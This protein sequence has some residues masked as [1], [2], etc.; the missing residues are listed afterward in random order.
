MKT[1]DICKSYFNG[2]RELSDSKH[3]GCGR[4]FISVLKV[5]S[6]FTGIVPLLFGIAYGISSSPCL[7][8]RVTKEISP[9]ETGKQGGAL[10]G[11]LK[12]T[13]QEIEEPHL[14]PDD[15]LPTL[16]LSDFSLNHL[17]NGQNLVEDR[18]RFGLLS[19]EQVKSI[20][21]ILPN[22]LLKFITV[23]QFKALDNL[24]CLEETRINILFAK[25]L[26]LLETLT[27]DQAQSVLPKLLVNNEIWNIH[28]FRC[29]DLFVH[30]DFSNLK[31][32]DVRNLLN[33]L[34][35]ESDFLPW[36]TCPQIE[37]M[38]PKICRLKLGFKIKSQLPLLNNLSKLTQEE[39]LNL[40]PTT[41]GYV[42]RNKRRFQLLTPKQIYSVLPELTPD[43]IAMFSVPQVLAIFPTMCDL[44]AT[45]VISEEQFN[46]LDLSELTQE[47]LLNLFPTT[48]GDVERNKRRFQLLTSD[49]IYSVLPQLTPDHMKFISPEQLLKLDKKQF[50]DIPPLLFKELDLSIVLEKFYSVPLSTKNYAQFATLSVP[51]VQAILPTMCALKATN[52]ISEEQ[53]NKLDLSELSYLDVHN[54]FDAVYPA[55]QKRLRWITEGQVRSIAHRLSELQKDFL[56]KQNPEAAKGLTP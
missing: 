35:A 38:L 29:N 7:T 26:K 9:K 36:F 16:D 27:L 15:V 41:E 8:G 46:K 53:F 55:G 51:Q 1:Q 19:P 18:Y 39:L 47:E 33:G 50:A 5:I 23:E 12:P 56:K 17:F 52:V 44:K 25:R 2:F 24:N 14:I 45:N 34:Q 6:L 20:L 11:L 21:E 4:N 54:T 42:E 28:S 3:L 13:A 48:E 40:L 43:H 31:D 37:Q 30:L 49:Q 32:E 22:S 10:N